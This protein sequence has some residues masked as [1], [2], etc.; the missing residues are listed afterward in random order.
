MEIKNYLSLNFI[1]NHLIFNFLQNE[2]S[3]RNDIN[4]S[5]LFYFLNGCI[6]EVHVSLSSIKKKPFPNA[7][8]SI[9]LR[10]LQ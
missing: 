1:H 10:F 3:E 9:N 6:I 2:N 7:F 8:S 4:R 5:Y